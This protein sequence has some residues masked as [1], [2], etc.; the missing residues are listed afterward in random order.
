[1]LYS[2]ILN[3]IHSVT[4]T[5]KA[6]EYTQKEMRREFKQFIKKKSTKQKTVIQKVRNKILSDK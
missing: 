3:V 4:Q 5:Q 2:R 1:M 6:I